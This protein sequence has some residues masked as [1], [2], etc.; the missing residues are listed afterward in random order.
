MTDAHELLAALRRVGALTFTA[1]SAVPTG[2]NGRGAGSV[3]IGSPDEGTVVFNESGTWT[4]TGSTQPIRFNN[5]FRWTRSGP[6]AVRLD[7]L[8]FGPEQPVHLFELAVESPSSWVS[9]A[10]HE[11]V[12][13][14]Y[15]ARLE[16]QDGAI[17]VRWS[18]VGPR[19]AE[20][21]AYVYRATP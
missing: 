14:R 4:P 6:F 18:I 20:D 8:R 12:D 13:D 11:C 10:D 3:G 5:V 19:K 17:H 7:H 9:R 16:L 15:S 2:W 21:I 1:R